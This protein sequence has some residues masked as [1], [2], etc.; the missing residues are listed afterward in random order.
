MAV[1]SRLFVKLPPPGDSEVTF[2]VF[3][4]SCH[5]L[6][7]VKP[8]QGRGN[9]VKCLVQG[10]NKLADLSSHYPFLMLNVKQESCE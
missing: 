4:S 8:L 6:L 1:F 2:A 5:L 9:L 7:S 3:K 10:H